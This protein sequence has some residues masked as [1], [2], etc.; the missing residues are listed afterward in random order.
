[1]FGPT[2]ELC[3]FA[4]EEALDVEASIG[5]PVATTEAG[6]QKRLL[7]IKKRKRKK[8]SVCEQ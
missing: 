5:L 8:F 6:M 1:M 2:E 7:F 3:F 4:G